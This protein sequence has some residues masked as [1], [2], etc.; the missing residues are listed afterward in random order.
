[1][2]MEM[3]WSPD[4][5]LACD[6]QTSGGAYCSQACRLAD[7][8]RASSGSDSS[9]P[10][11]PTAAASWASSALGTGSGFYLPPPLNFAAYMSTVS[12]RSVS[13]R[14]FAAAS[15]PTFRI[16]SFPSRSHSNSSN[17]IAGHSL[18]PILTTSTSRSSLS[19]LQGSSS[20]EGSVL[21]DQARNE[22]RDYASCF[23]QVR[24]WKRRVTV[25]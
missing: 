17:S 8:E 24:D 7:L 22:L 6:R 12:S 1:M 16:P 19:S 3:D 15:P 9:A 14:S 21:S 13:N 20:P 4:F 11:S 2:P 5:C 18:K 10:S 23:D 25:A